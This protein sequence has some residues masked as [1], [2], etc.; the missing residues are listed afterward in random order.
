MKQQINCKK[1]GKMTKGCDDAFRVQHKVMSGHL[2]VC[3]E[4]FDKEVRESFKPLED[5]I[6]E[7]KKF[8]SK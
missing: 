3:C 2:G 1:C 8:I 6:E 7:F 5:S 4:C